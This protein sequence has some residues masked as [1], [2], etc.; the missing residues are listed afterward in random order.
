MC[1]SKNFQP[2]EFF[3]S[4]LRIG[5]LQDADPDLIRL[6]ILKADLDPTFYF[7]VDPSLDLFY[8]T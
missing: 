6:S 3:L 5:K 4:V 8:L 7:D 1:L 2:M